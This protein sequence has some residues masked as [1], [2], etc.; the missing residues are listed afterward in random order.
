MTNT[1][2]FF[3]VGA[4]KC[5]TTALY[6]YL[7]EHPGIFMPDK[8]EPHYFANE[9]S[10]YFVVTRHKEEYL[11]LFSPAGSSQICGEAS[12]LYLQSEEAIQKVLSFNPDAKFIA[13]VRNPVDAAI[14]FHLQNIKSRYETE[15][16]FEKAWNLQKLRREGQHIP[17]KARDPSMLQYKELFSLGSQLERFV[18]LV[19]EDQRKIIVFDDF[20]KDT[21]AVYKEVIDF[22]G[23]PN[24]KADDF[25]VVNPTTNHMSPLLEK[26]LLKIRCQKY[27][28]IGPIIYFFKRF[29]I[30]YIRP[31]LRPDFQP[32]PH[33]KPDKAVYTMLEKEFYDEIIKMEKV[34]NR[35]FSH[36]LRYTKAS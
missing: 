33:Q 31:T 6:S 5:A 32:A 16:N 25:A 21:K 7:K 27:P 19:P 13:M 22:L 26:R 1:P 30:Y 2:D 28:V 10:D 4:P 15:E 23:L 20:K 11:D 12:V 8:K 3:I 34:L 35:D 9:L 14:S 24:D 36:W 17:E 29:Y 18:K